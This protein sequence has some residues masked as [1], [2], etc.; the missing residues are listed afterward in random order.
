MSGTLTDWLILEKMDL[1]KDHGLD[2]RGLDDLLQLF[3][4]LTLPYLG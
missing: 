1:C 4:F 3:S 2:G